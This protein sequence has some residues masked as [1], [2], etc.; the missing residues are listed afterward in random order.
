MVTLTV[1]QI[2]Y[3]VASCI[4]MLFTTSIVSIR[5]LKKT[6]THPKRVLI[7]LVLQYGLLPAI[8]FGLTRCFNFNDIASISLIL[9]STCPG[10]IF[11]NIFSFMSDANLPLSVSMTISSNI[12]SFASIP[13]NSIIYITIAIDYNDLIIDYISMLYFIPCI[14]F[15]FLVGLIITYFKHKLIRQICG[16]F[17]IISTLS[18]IGSMIAF[19]SFTAYSYS[20]QYYIAPLLLS[21]IGWIL[22]F[23]L[24]I[25]CKIDKSSAVSIAIE[26]SCQNTLIAVAILIL[27][28][29]NNDDEWNESLFIPMIYPLFTW[30]INIIFVSFC[31]IIGWIDSEQNEDENEGNYQGSLTLP[32]IFK[33]YRKYKKMN[34]P[35][36]QREF[37]DESDEEYVVELGKKKINKKQNG[38][39]NT[40]AAGGVD[41]TASVEVG[42]TLS[43]HGDFDV[44][45]R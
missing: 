34:E 39:I 30:C 37:C 13:I 26:V 18:L 33:N 5:Q 17:G 36:E 25:L 21:I 40:P 4:I 44:N 9:T 23:I 45:L 16:I 32:I 3:M 28:T 22:S 12:L 19:T 20:W 42:V 29:N 11:S 41:R 2:V 1:S 27:S 7:G 35:N 6:L 31:Y 8:A 38:R 43:Y 24:C 15:G 14:I 10:S